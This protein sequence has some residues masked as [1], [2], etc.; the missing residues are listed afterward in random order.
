MEQM[1][2]AQKLHVGIDP[3]LLKDGELLEFLGELLAS[4]VRRYIGVLCE[5]CGLKEMVD[6]G[7][8][9]LLE[10]L[11]VEVRPCSRHG[12]K[13]AECDDMCEYGETRLICVEGKGR[14]GAG[15]AVKVVMVL[16]PKGIVSDMVLKG[17]VVH[18]FV[19][20]LQ[21]LHEAGLLNR[22]CYIKCLWRLVEAG[23]FRLVD[24]YADDELIAAMLESV[25]VF[26]LY[27]SVLQEG[28]KWA[29]EVS[30]GE[31][32]LPLFA[33][34]EAMKLYNAARS[35]QDGERADIKGV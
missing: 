18:E 14:D 32:G 11:R 17:T 23:F 1:D 8:R 34:T 7:A 2:K 25:V 13:W 9:K 35:E 21:Y 20:V 33:D 4:K 26:V 27:P 5:V 16:Y 3:S 22:C 6:G 30:V 12:V 10:I 24:M 19:H 31:E 15:S 29:R 28:L